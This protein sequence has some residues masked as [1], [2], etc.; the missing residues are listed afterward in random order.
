M[1]SLPDGR[2]AVRD[3][4][5]IQ[6]FDEEGLFLQHVGLGTLGRCYGL[7]TDGMVRG[8]WDGKNCGKLSC[9]LLPATSWSRFKVGLMDFKSVHFL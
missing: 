3:D 9:T 5:G 2:F 7:T 6:L 4:L 8:V 1:V